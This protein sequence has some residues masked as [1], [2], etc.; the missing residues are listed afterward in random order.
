MKDILRLFR[1][2]V[3]N[4]TVMKQRL[5][6]AIYKAL[7]KT[8]MQGTHL[9]LDIANVAASAIKEVAKKHWPVPTYSSILYSVI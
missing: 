8:I 7:R 2:M 5:S 3:F 6:Q 4:D 9:G 1:S